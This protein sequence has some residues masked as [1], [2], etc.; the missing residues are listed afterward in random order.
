MWGLERRRR[1]DVA[2][3]EAADNILVRID[4]GDVPC[5][6]LTLPRSQNCFNCFIDSVPS[7][8]T[9]GWHF[10]SPEKN[11]WRQSRWFKKRQVLPWWVKTTCKDQTRIYKWKETGL[12]RDAGD[13]R[14]SKTTQDLWRGGYK[15]LK[16]SAWNKHK[17]QKKKW[18]TSSAQQRRRTW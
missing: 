10:Q 14:S 4:R 9:R 16:I 2:S 6:Y 11:K 15:D 12:S 7:H 17:C 18:E 1:I 8:R 13:R 5:D 3:G